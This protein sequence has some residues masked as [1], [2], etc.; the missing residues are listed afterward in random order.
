VLL[1]FILLVAS[2]TLDI[3]SDLHHEAQQHITPT[4]RSV[5]DF[6]VTLD[7]DSQACGVAAW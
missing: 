1:A 3:V 2:L 6:N 7:L 5:S 4:S